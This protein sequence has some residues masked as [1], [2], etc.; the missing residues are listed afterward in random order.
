MQT[1]TQ[2]VKD[3]LKSAFL[4]GKLPRRMMGDEPNCQKESCNKKSMVRRIIGPKLP[5]TQEVRKIRAVNSN[6]SEIQEPLAKR[7]RKEKSH[8]G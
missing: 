4:T 2:A 3:H 6:G 1:G 8:Q 5:E 7:T